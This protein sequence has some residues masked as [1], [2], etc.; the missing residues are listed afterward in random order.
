MYSDP[1]KQRDYQR[2]WMSARRAEYFEDKRCARCGTIENLELDHIDP[3]LKDTNSIWSWSKERRELELE[4]CQVL[5]YTCHKDKHKARHGTRYC[6]DRLRCRCA[7]CVT[8]NINR[9]RRQR[10]YKKVLCN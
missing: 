6:Y 4:K 3:R 9:R 1:Q 7:A 5:C 8:V 2:Q 10:A